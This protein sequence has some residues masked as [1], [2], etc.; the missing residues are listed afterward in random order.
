M[1]S[2]EFRRFVRPH[3]RSEED[4]IDLPDEVAA[5]AD[6]LK[7]Q[8]WQFEIEIL[9]TGQVNADVCDRDEQLASHL[10]PNN[11]TVPPS[12]E[13]MIRRAHARWTEKGKPKAAGFGTRAASRDLDDLCGND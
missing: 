6:E 2:V 1:A 13:A 10:G 5:L 12:L 8:G 4:Y 3:G 7:A 9:R 11:E